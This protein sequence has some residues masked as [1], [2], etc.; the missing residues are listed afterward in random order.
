MFKT[1]PNAPTIM[2]RIMRPTSTDT[3]KPK[4][5]SEAIQRAIVEEYGRDA[6]SHCQRYRALMLE[7]A[8]QS[9]APWYKICNAKSLWRRASTILHMQLSG[10]HGGTRRVM[11]SF[12]DTAPVDYSMSVAEQETLLSAFSQRTV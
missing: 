12:P 2:K 11:K 10:P 9:G 3:S 8:Y 7:K 1:K 4:R 6:K 5:P